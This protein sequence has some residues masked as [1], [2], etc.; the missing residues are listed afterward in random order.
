MQ[1]YDLVR[2]HYSRDTRFP[3]GQLRASPEIANF[4]SGFQIVKGALAFATEP[5]I[6]EDLLGDRHLANLPVLVA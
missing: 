2:A 1:M 5:P 4:F 6:P 3:A